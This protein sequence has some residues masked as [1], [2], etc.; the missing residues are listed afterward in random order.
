VSNPAIPKPK[1]TAITGWAGQIR[2][3]SET[4]VSIGRVRSLNPHDPFY[5]Y[6]IK[7]G[8]KKPPQTVYRSEEPFKLITIVLETKL[9]SDKGLEQFRSLKDGDWVKVDLFGAQVAMTPLV[10]F[11]EKKNVEYAVYGSLTV[12][13]FSAEMYKRPRTNEPVVQKIAVTD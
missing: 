2:L 6:D 7:Q 12:R 9:M 13:E 4:S 5:E 8:M 10:S 1:I 11:A 3:G